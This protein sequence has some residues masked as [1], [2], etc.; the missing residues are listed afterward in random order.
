MR[1]SFGAA[2]PLSASAVKKAMLS[3][4]ESPST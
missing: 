3:A 2:S 1:A 4:C